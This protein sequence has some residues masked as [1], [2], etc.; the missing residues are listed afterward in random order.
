MYS[1]TT[2]LSILTFLMLIAFFCVCLDICNKNIDKNTQSYIL[3]CRRHLPF[4]AILK[5]SNRPKNPLTKCSILSYLQTEP[6]KLVQHFSLL[7]CWMLKWTLWSV[8]VLISPKSWN[9]KWSLYGT[10]VLDWPLSG[11]P[12]E[13]THGTAC[14]AALYIPHVNSKNKYEYD[15]ILC[16]SYEMA[17]QE[18][19]LFCKSETNKKYVYSIKRRRARTE[20]VVCDER[21][22]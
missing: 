3:Q 7:L 11:S 18:E 2:S 1:L 22:V 15:S 19:Y 8:H 6:P 12:P 5:V 21:V 9:S 4:S 17:S 13:V 14:K 20:S 10:L 16:K